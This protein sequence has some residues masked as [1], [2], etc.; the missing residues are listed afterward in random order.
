MAGS[1]PATWSSRPLR[2]EGAGVTLITRLDSRMYEQDLTEA[3]D[4]WGITLVVGAGASFASNIPTWIELLNRIAGDPVVRGASEDT[5]RL[6]V[7]ANF[8]LPSIATYLQQLHGGRP[9]DY[10]ECV[11]HNLYRDFAFPPGADY[12]PDEVLRFLNGNTTL[13]SLAAMC[14]FKDTARQQTQSA[15]FSANPRIHDVITFN[16]D[17]LLETLIRNKYPSGR[18]LPDG[19]YRTIEKPAASSQHGRVNIYHLHGFLR[20]DQHIGKTDRESVSLVLSEQD[21]FDFFNSPT[22]MFTYTFLS[23]LRE[24]PCLFVGLSMVDENL[25]RLLH[26]SVQERTASYR[27][28]KLDEETARRR[29]ARHF[30]ILRSESNRDRR[31]ATELTLARLGVRLI[32]VDEYLQIREILKSLYE[33]LDGRRW[34]DVY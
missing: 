27:S 19:V 26:Y 12:S 21:Y 29:S 9:A 3:Y 23:R 34:E 11:R 7:E 8:S 1:L 16:I 5:V 2:A 4:K 15:C 20:F 14:V 24:N 30:A 18:A 28:E 10:I 33:S 32:W 31:S 6:L 17:A 13:R 25:R 22:N